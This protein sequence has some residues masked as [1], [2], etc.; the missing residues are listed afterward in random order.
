MT[1][2]FI[3]PEPYSAPSTQSLVPY[4]TLLPR[5]SRV[6]RSL[7]EQWGPREPEGPCPRGKGRENRTQPDR[8]RRPDCIQDTRLRFKYLPQ[9]VALAEPNYTVL[10]TRLVGHYPTDRGRIADLQTGLRDEV[11]VVQWL[12]T[13]EPNPNATG[14]HLHAWGWGDDFS[15]DQLAEQAA[16]VGYG[17]T[18]MKPV[19]Y[20]GDFGYTAK[21]ATHNQA[22]LTEHIRLNGRE[23]IHGRGF[24][25]DAHTG[26]S[27]TQREART[28]ARRLTREPEARTQVQTRAQATA[29]WFTKNFQTLPPQSA[30]ALR[31]EQPKSL[32]DIETGEIVHTLG[33]RADLTTVR[34]GGQVGALILTFRGH[35]GRLRLLDSA[36]GGVRIVEYRSAA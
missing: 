35:D 16:I 2:S 36:K 32:V 33:H 9:M 26:E 12:W 30:T 3:S 14:Y 17:V 34:G 7:E 28:R 20:H 13:I 22:S 31:D 15:S 18:D 11:G 4:R 1:D 27:M 10:L 24:F 8:C 29:S 23:L 19:T 25:R 5:T 6:A 21:N